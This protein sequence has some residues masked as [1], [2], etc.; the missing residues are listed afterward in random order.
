[1]KIPDKFIFRQGDLVTVKARVRFDDD[2]DTRLQVE[3]VGSPHTRTSLKREELLSLE[4]REW[5]A[6]DGVRVR[7][8]SDPAK[9][10]AF[11]KGMAWIEY[12][13]GAMST[14][15]ALDLEVDPST[16]EEV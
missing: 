16:P 14:Y 10:V 11:H 12:P 15:A 5:Q 7:N 1:M 3:L 8:S 2:M 6:G 4:G 9:V 13:S